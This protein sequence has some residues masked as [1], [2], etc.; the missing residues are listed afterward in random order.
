MKRN[1]GR[2]GT[3][4]FFIVGTIAHNEGFSWYYSIFF[5]GIALALYLKSEDFS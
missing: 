2:L 3:I 4:I 5:W 1:W